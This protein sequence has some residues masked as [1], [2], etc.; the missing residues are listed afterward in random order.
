MLHDDRGQ[1]RAE[2]HARLDRRRRRR[3]RTGSDEPFGRVVDRDVHRPGSKSPGPARRR[4]RHGVEVELLGERPAD[5]VDDGELGGALVRLG[6]AGASSRRT[7]GRCRGRRPCSRRG[8]S[9]AARRPRRRRA[10]RGSRGDDTDDASPARIGTQ[11]RLVIV[12][13]IWIAPVAS[14]ASCIARASDLVVMTSRSARARARRRAAS[15][16]ALV[17][18]VRRRRCSSPRRT[19]RSHRLRGR[20]SPSRS[21]T[22]SM[23]ASKSSW[24]R[25]PAPISLMSDK[26]GVTLAGLLDRAG[27]AQGRP[28][29]SAD[30]GEEFEVVVGIAMV[31]GIGLDDDAPKARPSAVSGAPSQSP[32]S[33]RRR[34]TRS[35]LAP[36]AR[37]TARCRLGG[38]SRSQDVR[39]RPARS[40]RRRA[41]TLRVR[42]VRRPRRRSTGS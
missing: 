27:S 31:G 18:L 1:A 7:V 30:E 5:L 11:P 22:I 20:R 38:R 33:G 23:I 25:G 36:R 6:R 10:A 16:V 9:G 12:P 8:S 40:R 4:G 19:G 37:G 21:P 41:P 17:D 32:A 35:L 29:V 28:D 14:L 13:P 24:G 34:R 2:R 42:D 39:R 26:L 15:A 3:S